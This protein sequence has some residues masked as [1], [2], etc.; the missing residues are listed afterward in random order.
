V[1]R[2]SL[3]GTGCGD[4]ETVVFF[5]GFASGSLFSRAVRDSETVVFLRGRGRRL[6]F[7]RG[8]CDSE[9]VVVSA[10]VGGTVFVFS[11][12]VKFGNGGCIGRGSRVGLCFLADRAIWKRARFRRFSG[13]GLCFFAG[14]AIRKRPVF[15]RRS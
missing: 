4:S 7:S 11:R 12:V 13:E 2:F 6:L 14:R 15:L 3:R 10:V 1:A 5:V 9:T 8:P